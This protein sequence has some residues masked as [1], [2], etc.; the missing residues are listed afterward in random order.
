MALLRWSTYALLLL[1]I[2]ASLA[3]LYIATEHTLREADTNKELLLRVC[4]KENDK[5]TDISD[6]CTKTRVKSAT[7]FIGRFMQKLVFD[8]S[9]VVATIF[10]K[11]T[12]SFS[13]FAYFSLVFV[14]LFLVQRWAAPAAP[15]PIHFYPIPSPHDRLSWQQQAEVQQYASVLQRIL[16]PSSD[17]S[18]STGPPSAFYR[19]HLEPRRPVSTARLVELEDD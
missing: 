12:S 5:F 3:W 7:P 17:A 10:D 4:T 18:A 9:D 11:V 2:C 1:V 19:G 13:V 14:G 8:I 15:P 16:A 6:L